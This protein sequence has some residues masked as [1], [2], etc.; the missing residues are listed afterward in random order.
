VIALLIFIATYGQIPKFCQT[1]SVQVPF[2][3]RGIYIPYKIKIGSDSIFVDSAIGSDANGNGSKSNPFKSIQKG[4]DNSSNGNTVII[5]NGTYKGTGNVNISPKGK[6]II[7]QSK[8][9]P[10]YTSIDGEN[11]NR[12]FLLNSGESSTT[13]IR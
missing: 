6:S 3:N 8:N 13:I 7:I 4:I 2:K 10:G 9:G 12:G 1:T 5:G 11:Q